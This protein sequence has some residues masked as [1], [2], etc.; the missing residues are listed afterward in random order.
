MTNQAYELSAIFIY[1]GIL[2]AIGVFSY[3]KHLSAADFLIGS[4]SL[5]YWLT[6]LA[7]HASDMSSWMF[8]GY[9]AAIFLTGYTG[10]WTGVGLIIF[11]FL[12]WQLVAPKIRV[13][14]EK[15]SS[16][17][18]SSFFESRLADTSGLIR[19]FTALISLFFYTIYISA[20]F[21]GLGIL[22]DTLFGIPYYLGI[23]LGILIVV[24]YVFIGGYL[25]LAWLDLFQGLFLMAVILFVPFYILPKVGGFAGISQ[26]IASKNLV[27]TMFPEFSAQ[28]YLNILLTICGFGLGYFGQPHIVTKFMGIKHVEETNKSK[29]IGMSWMTIS[30]FAATLVGL[31]SIPYFFQGIEN[32]EQVFIL[33][34][35]ENFHPILIGFFLCGILAATINN[36]GSQVLVLSST[37]T[38]DFYKRVFRKIASSRELLLVS[39]LGVVLVTLIAFVIAFFKISTIYSLVQ[40]AW[41]GLGASFGPLLLLCLYSK[42]VTKQGAWAGII[43]GSLISALW[44]LFSSIPPL[45]PGFFGNLFAILMVSKLKK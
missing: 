23:L 12:N 14:T 39:R 17:T 16:L 31:V 43:V 19:L 35:T 15:F 32:S 41:S 24:P 22:I 29:W 18:F 11:M 7:A 34:V 25:T 40:Y 27:G 33:M 28:N 45:I 9:P 42:K 21:V 37:L 44:P 36:I 20:G 2:V 6:A 3:R 30:L 4:R 38:E 8:M 10:A 26:A 5:N 13:A 1:L